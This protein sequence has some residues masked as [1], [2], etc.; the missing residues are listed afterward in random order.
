M[1]RRKTL[2][3]MRPE[4]VLTHVTRQCLYVY[5]A[6]SKHYNGGTADSTSCSSRSLLQVSTF[7]R[8]LWRDAVWLGETG[9]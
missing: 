1:S 6:D 4:C 8:L 3:G 7:L 5:V 9:S 2:I